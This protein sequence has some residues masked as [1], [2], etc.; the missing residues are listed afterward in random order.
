MYVHM[1]LIIFYQ[2]QTISYVEKYSTTT[3]KIFVL[4][5]IV[6]HILIADRQLISLMLPIN[7]HATLLPVI[8]SYL[9]QLTA[10]I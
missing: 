4:L 6:Y 8:I 9:I 7:V 3:I 5:C 1:H 2:I 10:L